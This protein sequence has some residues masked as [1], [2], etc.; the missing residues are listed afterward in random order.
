[1][2]H[3]NSLLRD[4]S[5]KNDNLVETIRAILEQKSAPFTGG[6]ADVQDLSGPNKP[7]GRSEKE[8]HHGIVDE[9]VEEIEEIHNP[10]KAPII[11]HGGLGG[12]N[13]QQRASS[14]KYGNQKRTRGTYSEARQI[15]MEKVK[16]KKTGQT[17]TKQQPE[18]VDVNPEMKPMNGNY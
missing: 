18:S 11:G 9:D 5:M 4:L 17:D 16:N 3:L 7:P 8:Q 12:K 14:Q 1:M 15:A 10:K 6:G 13:L 2:S